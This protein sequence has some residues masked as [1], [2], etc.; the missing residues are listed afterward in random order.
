MTA[1][2]LTR[3]LQN[4]VESQQSGLAYLHGILCERGRRMHEMEAIIR[5]Q[6]EIIDTFQDKPFFDALAQTVIER[7]HERVEELEAEVDMLRAER[8]E[9]AY[10]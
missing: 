4:T 3:S 2:D 1:S 6:Q 7:L 10:G 8:G 5:E 9:V